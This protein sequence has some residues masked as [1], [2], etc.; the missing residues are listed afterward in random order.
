[1]GIKWKERKGDGKPA[2]KSA[3]ARLEKLSDLVPR[4]YVILHLQAARALVAPPPSVPDVSLRHR[5]TRGVLVSARW[6]RSRPLARGELHPEIK[7]LD[8]PQGSRRMRDP[9]MLSFREARG[10]DSQ[11]RARIELRELSRY[12]GGIRWNSVVAAQRHYRLNDYKQSSAKCSVRCYSF[13]I[14]LC[15]EL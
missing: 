13:E 3:P 12:V 11:S 14:I 7:N 1:M 4:N 6:T 9:G 2:F 8:K 5:Q 10:E 15:K